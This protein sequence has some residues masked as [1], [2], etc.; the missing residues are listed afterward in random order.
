MKSWASYLLILL[1]AMQSVL[2]M[3]DAQKIH[4]SEAG[5]HEYQDSADNA[6]TMGDVPTDQVMDCKHCCHGHCSQLIVLPGTVSNPSI[7]NGHVP[8]VSFS[9]VVADSP[10]SSLFRPPRA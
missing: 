8:R 6:G 1:I 4:Q 9:N 10:P 5:H 2:A 7:S 3:A